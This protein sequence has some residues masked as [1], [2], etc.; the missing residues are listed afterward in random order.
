MKN[1]V[2][3]TVAACAAVLLY[4]CAVNPPPQVSHD[5]LELRPE[6]GL[7]QVYVKPGASLA[8]YEGF[9]LDDCSVAF[10]KNWLRDQNRDRISLSSRVTQKD[11][12]RIRDALAADCDKYFREA[13]QQDPAY[14]LVDSFSDGEAVLVLKPGIINLDVA[15]PDVMSPGISRTYTTSAGEATLFL[16]IADGTTGET[17]VRVVDRRRGMDTGRLE[18]TNSVTNRADADRALRYWAGRLREGLDRAAAR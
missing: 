8:D 16:E 3:R 7:Q 12:D 2:W 1:S 14:Q 18:W 6:A 13:L 4:G 10:R 17:L 9:G 11:V 5:G 15:A